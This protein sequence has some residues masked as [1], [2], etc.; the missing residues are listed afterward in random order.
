MMNNLQEEGRYDANNLDE[1]EKI[2]YTGSVG[3]KGVHHGFKTSA[4]G[5]LIL[6]E[7]FFCGAGRIPRLAKSKMSDP[8]RR[9]EQNV[10]SS[11]GR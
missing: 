6:S 8:T 9:N 3:N 4:V 7:R 2:A 11:G 5:P 1:Q 10:D